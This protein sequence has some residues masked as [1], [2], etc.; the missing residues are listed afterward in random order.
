MSRME[1][2]EEVDDWQVEENTGNLSPRHSQRRSSVD[3]A[4]IFHTGHATV[5]PSQ[6]NWIQHTWLH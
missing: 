4:Q 1:E 6:L 2:H 5:Y 3:R